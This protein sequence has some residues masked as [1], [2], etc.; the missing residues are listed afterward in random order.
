LTIAER[1]SHRKFEHAPLPRT[2]Y[3][4]KHERL[5]PQ[6]GGALSD[7]RLDETAGDGDGILKS[8]IIGIRVRFVEHRLQGFQQGR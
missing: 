7:L 5:C 4:L 1:H 8:A 3:R 6:F 2:L